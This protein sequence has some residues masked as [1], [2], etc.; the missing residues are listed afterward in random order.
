[1]DFVKK[2][3]SLIISSF[4]IFF[5]ELGTPFKAKLWLVLIPFLV[6][7]F[8]FLVVIQYKHGFALNDHILIVGVFEKIII[9]SLIL[10]CSIMFLGIVTG[11]SIVPAIFM[12][13]YLLLFFSDLTVYYFGHTMLESHH[14]DLITWYSIKGFIGFTT[15]LFLIMFLIASAGSFF[16]IKKLRNRIRFSDLFRYAIILAV[17][18]FVGPTDILINKSEEHDGNFEGNEDKNVH[19]ILRCK[20]AQIRYASKNSLVNFWQEIL[21]KKRRGRYTLERSYEEFR[22]TIEKYKLPIGTRSYEPLDIEPFDHIIWFASESINLDFFTTYNDQIPFPTETEFYESEEIIDKMMLNYYTAASPT[23][24]AMVVTFSSHPNERLLLG[25]YHQNSIVR[26][27][28]AHGY[29]T[30]FLRSAS[31]YYAGENI[32]FQKFGFKDIIAREYFSQFPENADYIYDLSLIH[33]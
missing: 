13:I 1:M 27:L 29:H 31:K 19:Y 12:M 23:L 6:V 2:F 32:V 16:L 14:L 3:V 17:L 15:V 30:V 4:K 5:K 21:F 8:I 20:N 25:G 9:D 11:T 33:I 18:I 7:E 10:L 24:Q 26:I 28:Q 22:P